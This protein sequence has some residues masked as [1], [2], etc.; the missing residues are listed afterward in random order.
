[1]FVKQSKVSIGIVLVYILC[2]EP[3]VVTSIDTAFHLWFFFLQLI[4][5]AIDLGVTLDGLWTLRTRFTLV[6]GQ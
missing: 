2:C 4:S 5:S 6:L 1:M 3:F